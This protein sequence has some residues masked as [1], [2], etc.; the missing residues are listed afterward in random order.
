MS[1]S[2]WASANLVSLAELLDPVAARLDDRLSFA[3]P[4]AGA[5]RVGRGGHGGR[6]GRAS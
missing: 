6:R 4:L 1:R 5:L 2:E 3:G